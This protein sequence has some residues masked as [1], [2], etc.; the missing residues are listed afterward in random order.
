MLK[1]MLDKCTPLIPDRT[2]TCVE[3]LL[4]LILAIL[5]SLTTCLS[6]VKHHLGPATAA[7]HRH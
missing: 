2:L 1:P 7:F 3:N 4:N 6:E 5:L